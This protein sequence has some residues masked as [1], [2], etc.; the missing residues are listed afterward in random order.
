LGPPA[1]A[2]AGV[3]CYAGIEVVSCFTAGWYVD[4]GRRTPRCSRQES[5]VFTRIAAALMRLLR[6]SASLHP[7]VFCFTPF[8]ERAGRP[9]HPRP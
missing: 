4:P 1:D 3:V 9:A 5:V 2:A 8:T 7:L 6:G